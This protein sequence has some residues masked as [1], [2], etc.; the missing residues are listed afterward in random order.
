GRDD[1]DHGTTTVPVEPV[2][3]LR[4]VTEAPTVSD[5]TAGP[6]EPDPTEAALAPS[7]PG[8]APVIP[9]RRRAPWILAAAAAG[10]VVGAAGSGLLSN[11]GSDEP[12]VVAEAA[13]EP[14]PGWE[15]T[16]QAAVEVNA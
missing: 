3:P 8:L 14:L 6:S 9:L 10:V 16:G 15:A 7:G 5:R 1:G 2:A 4:A 12:D 13:L 11:L